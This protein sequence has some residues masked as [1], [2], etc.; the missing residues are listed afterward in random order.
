MRHD[1]VIKL[2][3]K[4][5]PQGVVPASFYIDW[6]CI[7]EDVDEFFIPFCEFWAEGISL[8]PFDF[9]T[10]HVRSPNQ[11]FDLALRSND[12]KDMIGFALFGGTESKS[13]IGPLAGGYIIKPESVGERAVYAMPKGNMPIEIGTAANILNIM[14]A[15]LQV[16]H[17]K[18]VSKVETI[19][20]E[21]L[22]KSRSK[23]GK[24]KLRNY[25]TVS[26]NELSRQHLG[27]DGNGKPKAPHWRRGHLR[28][29]NTGRVVPVHA[30]IVNWSGEQVDPKTYIVKK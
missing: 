3:G 23:S 1:D 15:A 25:I 6:D 2:V 22:N 21:K 16:I 13:V 29:L 4:T 9:M 10:L 7:P 18:D 26:L 14:M 27:V 17:S 20:G 30:C 8:M 12:E 28:R 5:I 11:Y 24:Q 19:I